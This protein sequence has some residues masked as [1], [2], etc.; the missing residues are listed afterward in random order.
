MPSITLMMSTI[1]FAD[2]LISAMVLTIC[3]TI[4][5]PFCAMRR[6]S[7]ASSLACTALS[8]FCCTVLES[9][10]VA[11]AVSSRAL[12][13]CSVREDRSSVPAATWAEALAM[14][15]APV[16][17]LPTARDK[18]ERMPSMC[19]SMQPISSVPLWGTGWDKSLSAICLSAV[20]A[21]MHPPF[22]R[23]SRAKASSTEGTTNSS[24]AAAKIHKAWV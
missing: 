2:W 5:P 23:V 21:V 19:C 18:F 10:S 12:A 7:P 1:F 8:A 9:S 11:A 3:P 17:T 20:L 14:A 13:C 22:K 4:S 15:P 6:A 16:L 24:R